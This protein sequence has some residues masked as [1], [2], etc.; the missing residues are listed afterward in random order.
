MKD[1]TDIVY[2]FSE[3]EFMILLASA[4][5]EHLPCFQGEL[6]S[7]AE[8]AEEDYN[9]QIF[10]LAKRGILKSRGDALY[11]P[12]KYALLF[13]TIKRRKM[14]LCLH[15]RDRLSYFY[16]GENSA[17]VEAQSAA[18]VGAY[19]RLGY[20]GKEALFAGIR[21]DLPEAVVPDTVYKE[22]EEEQ[23][24]EEMEEIGGLE[25]TDERED[26]IATWRFFEWRGKLY[27]EKDEGPKKQRF[28]VEEFAHILKTIMED[29]L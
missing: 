7:V 10:G 16:I 22:G 3:K 1:I 27:T 12:E 17:A 13:R 19:V 11:M 14:T 26:L 20:L 4:A 23:L 25:L 24:P 15:F 28:L 9:R 21:E 29:R 2:H 18:E 8:I 6:A 5:V